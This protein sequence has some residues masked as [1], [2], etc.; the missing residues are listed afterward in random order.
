MEFIL[1]DNDNAFRLDQNLNLS[2][3]RNEK[4]IFTQP[5]VKRKVEMFSAD[6][7][8]KGDIHIA[9]VC[10]GALTYIKYSD[11]KTST[12]HL[13]HLPENF[14]ITSLIINCENRLRLNYC[15]KSKSGCAVIEYTNS[16]DLW[17]G[18]NI[19][20]CQENM[21]LKYVK[22]NK[23]E[24][25]VVKDNNNSYMLINA[26]E[27][28]NVVFESTNPINEVQGVFDGA[29]WATTEAAY[30]NG[31]EI[32]KGGRIYAPDLKRVIID[33]SGKLKEFSLDNGSRYWGEVSLPANAKEYILCVAKNDKR[34]ILSTPYP[35]IRYELQK[36]VGAGVL[37]EVYMQQRSLFQLQ[38]EIKSLK[39]RVKRLE[40]ALSHY[41]K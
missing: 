17:Q 13:M 29:I 38:A 18:K 33:D 5:L 26:Y 32:S 3:S 1:I 25:F 30:F 19:Y 4:I 39:S 10:G 31:G 6:I 36:K 41:E 8:E 9:A 34:K 22:K 37:E 40:D 15:V 7:D 20:T 28:D 35:Y 14:S 27:P 2:L 24:C 12:V 23:N 21:V 16:G 11:R